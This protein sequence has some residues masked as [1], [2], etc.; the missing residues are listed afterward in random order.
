MKTLNATKPGEAVTL[1]T[2]TNVVNPFDK[3]P[4]WK[5][6]RDILTMMWFARCPHCKKNFGLGRNPGESYLLHLAIKEGRKNLA[7]I[8]DGAEHWE[9]TRE[10]FLTHKG[11]FR[12][13]EGNHG[14]S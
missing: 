13:A 11:T 3:K 1:E 12:R 6:D 14:T 9:M 8:N 5:F 10:G 4:G 2:P 7:C